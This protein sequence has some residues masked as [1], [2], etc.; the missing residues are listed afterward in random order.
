MKAWINKLL[1]II[2]LFVIL[3]LS[4]SEILVEYFFQPG[5]DSCEKVSAFVLPR[6]EEEFS[7]EYKLIRYDVSKEE[8]FLKLAAYQER[9]SPVGNDP[10]CIV[11]N[12][13]IYLG[14]YSTID[15]RIYKHMRQL[16]SAETPA[17]GELKSTPGHE[18][19]ER[20]AR[21]FTFAAI[22]MA[23]LADGVNPC[24]FST[25]I[26]FIS[27]LA[28]LKIRGRRLL[29]TG[30]V[31]CLACFL[32]YLTLGLGLLSFLRLF[33]GYTMIQKLFDVVL[34]TMLIVFALISFFDA[35]RFSRRGKADQVILRLPEKLKMR[36]HQLMRKGLNYR[37]LI[38]AAFGLG[39]AVTLLESVCTGQV[40]APV[41]LFMSRH[42]DHAIK[43]FMLLILYNLMFIMPLIILFAAA[44][45]G[46]PLM[47]F[48]GWSKNNA[49]YGKI[50]LGILFATLA[51]LTLYLH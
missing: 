32:T 40:Y 34:P 29:L 28:T 50:F 49:V 15:D 42:S 25:L 38:P 36:I 18:L 20:R 33:S 27:L 5:C 24:V 17:A 7:G 39:M 26:F 41:L 22:I 1:V 30:S 8:N 4:A 14:G 48:I 13:E 45:K 21:G 9:F 31:Y 46:V 10:V 16:I 3:P 47:R 35:W 12:R 23:G 19:M 6:L 37:F 51:W 11:L 2:P 44:Y 43:Y